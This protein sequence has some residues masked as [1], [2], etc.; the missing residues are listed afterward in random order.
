ME[1]KEKMWMEILS[2]KRKLGEAA[3][4][5]SVSRQSV[6]KWLAQHKYAW[7]S[8][9]TPKK[10]WPKKNSFVYNKVSSHLESLVIEIARRDIFVW[11]I[12]IRDTLLTETWEVLNQSTI[13]RILKRNRVRYFNGYH[14]SRKNR[15]LYVKDMPWREL[16][17]D[18][19]FAWGL[20]EK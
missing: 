12:G 6:S 8:G 18:V 5:L 1:I 10:S 4:I 14:G 16:Q 15:I 3:D 20:P 19:S 9:I 13:Y 17:V 7:I 11:L 2:K